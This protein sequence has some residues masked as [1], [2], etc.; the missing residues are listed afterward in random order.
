LFLL[1]VCIACSVAVVQA[2]TLRMLPAQ[3]ERGKLGES[4]PLPFVKIGNR[5]L[6]L[7]PGGVIYDEQNRSVVHA[8][9]P[10]SAEV[11]YTKNPTGDIQRIYILTEQEKA[12]LDQSRKR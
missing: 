6:R 12:R 3:G 7:A 2:Q 11:F 1:I 4:Q 10:P 5:V 9:L 8:H